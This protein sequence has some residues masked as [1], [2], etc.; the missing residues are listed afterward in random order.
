MHYTQFRL[1]FYN[2]LYLG[3]PPNPTYSDTV[4]LD[5][6]SYGSEHNYPVHTVVC[7]MQ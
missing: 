5:V 3:A 1:S 2:T 4:F 6:L 7:I